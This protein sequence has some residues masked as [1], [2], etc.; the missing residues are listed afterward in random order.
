MASPPP[1]ELDTGSGKT[2][3]PT[4]ETANKRRSRRWLLLI[5]AGAALPV[6]ALL[7]T[8]DDDDSSPPPPAP[9]AEAKEAPPTPLEAPEALA[10]AALE[11]SSQ[12][13]CERL[14]NLIRHVN[15]TLNCRRD[16]WA[17]VKLWCE[18][19]I[20]ARA[21]CA[22]RWTDLANCAEKV[23]VSEWVCQGPVLRMKEGTCAREAEVL[24]RCAEP[25]PSR[26]SAG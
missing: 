20:K 17:T 2:T 1:G 9:G 12:P 24:K 5:A 19:T 25:V 18:A 14:H 3:A 7:L 10:S 23:P 8:P 11:P 21:G 4:V 26:P 15:T 13:V 6:A 16:D 22:D